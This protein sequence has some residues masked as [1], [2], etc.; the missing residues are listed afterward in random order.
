MVAQLEVA[1]DNERNCNVFFQPLQRTIRGAYDFGR[2][3]EPESGRL[4]RR[5][6]GRPIP[7][8]VLGIEGERGYVRDGVHGDDEMLHLAQQ[9][10]LKIPPER[11]EVGEVDRATWLYWLR[12]AVDAGHA[13][14]VSGK[15][16]ELTDIEGEPQK[17]F[18]PRP[19]SPTDEKLDRL[20]D[21]L[22]KFVD[23]LT[24]QAGK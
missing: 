4:S 7:G 14:V 13:R 16:P 10:G 2:C 11:E 5:F 9:R 12:R 6:N 1:I 23:L 21:T 19:K 18:Q 24:K 22:E 17:V 8:Q 3:P 15:L 20:T